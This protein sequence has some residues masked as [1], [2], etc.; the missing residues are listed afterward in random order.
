LLPGRF[1]RLAVGIYLAMGWSGFM[2]YDTVV[3][4]RRP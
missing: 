1:D 4:S 3:A 2:V